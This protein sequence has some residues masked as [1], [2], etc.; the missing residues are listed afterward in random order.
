MKSSKKLAAAMAVALGAGGVVA[1]AIPNTA[2]AASQ[3]FTVFSQ[4][5]NTVLGAAVAQ[6][7]NL[8]QTTVTPANPNVGA[9]ITVTA[10]APWDLGS[11]PATGLGAETYRIDAVITIGTTDY[12]IT[13]PRNKVG[14]ANPNTIVLDSWTISSTQGQSTGAL[15]ATLSDALGEGSFTLN[16]AGAVSA[17][18]ANLTAPA[19]AGTYAIGVK[20]FV[21]NN[22]STVN[23]AIG[24]T[25]PAY[26]GAWANSGSGT[27]DIGDSQVFD[28]MYNTKAAPAP[29]STI[30]N[31]SGSFNFTTPDSITVI[32]PSASVSAVGGQ[33]VTTHV[34]LGNTAPATPAQVSFTGTTWGGPFAVGAFTAAYCNAAGTVCDADVPNTLSSTAG[35]ALSGNV[36]AASGSSSATGSRSI[37]ITQGTR[38]VVV[39]IIVLGAPVVTLTPAGGPAGTITAIGG[40]NFNPSTAVSA[41]AAST[42][43]PPT[44]VFVPGPPTALGSA[45]AS[46]VLVPGPTTQFTVSNL[47]TV[48]IV[49]AQGTTPTG[50][51]LVTQPSGFASWLFAT[52]NCVAYVGNKTL[53]GGAGTP[54]DPNSCSTQQI[55]NVSVLQG[56]LV[57]KAYVNTANATSTGGATVTNGNPAS[58][59]VNGTPL[60]N[61]DATT[62]NLGTISVPLAP[63]VITGTLNDIQVS[64]NRG[65]TFG[66]SLT[67]TMPD[68]TSQQGVG[69]TIDN[70]KLAANPTCVKAG[71]PGTFAARDFDTGTAIA[72]YDPLFSA[73]AGAG[74][75]GNFG[76]TVNLC[77]KA[78]GTI[79]SP[80][81]DPGYTGSTGGVWNI[82][83]P[84]VLSVPAFQASGKYSSTMQVLLA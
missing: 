23:P 72:G 30:Q 38:S 6:G 81:S 13:G 57:Q 54:L 8:V 61:T 17:P 76:G 18:V 2:Q 25:S 27:N 48:G 75:A 3:S 77:T 71:T 63:V 82:S 83:S 21:W 1:L 52:D 41:L 62:V 39:P 28:V 19:A 11:G 70:A 65:G 51:P 78:D 46:G 26:A 42:Y 45:D 35:G 55:V 24:M 40:N 84:L 29:W 32:G 50:P 4:Q 66:W 10:T 47:A 56:R 12:L 59:P 34:R 44:V 60:A 74:A 64:D 43:A 73:P 37:R 16:A 68:F 31:G 33:S 53:G 7:S 14:T 20:T 9:P 79:T 67:A 58:T 80:A 15:G 49:V 5:N 69:A 36:S 22:V